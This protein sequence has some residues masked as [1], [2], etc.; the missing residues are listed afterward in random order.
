M[1]FSGLSAGAIDEILDVFQSG[2]DGGH[3]AP[4]EQA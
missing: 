1:A 4:P 3:D 2:V